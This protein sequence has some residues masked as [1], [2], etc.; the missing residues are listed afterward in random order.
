MGLVHSLVHQGQYAS[1]DLVL[2]QL[3][4]RRGA[5]T[6]QELGVHSL[7]CLD[8]LWALQQRVAIY[9]N[10]YMGSQSLV[11]YLDFEVDL[12]CTLAAFCLPP[13]RRLPCS[14]SLVLPSSSAAADPNELDIDIDVDAAASDATSD[15]G[16]NGGAGE[17]GEDLGGVGVVTRTMSFAAFGVGPLLMHP[18]VWRLF[19]LHLPAVVGS[20][21]CRESFLSA[22]EALGHLL[23][24]SEQ[25]DQAATSSSSFSSSSS[26]SSYSSPSSAEDFTEGYRQSLARRL[27]VQDVDGF[28]FGSVGLVVRGD[29]EQE[30]VLLCHVARRRKERYVNACRAHF[31]GQ[32]SS[33]DGDD[34]NGGGT[35]TGVRRRRK[36]KVVE[37]GGEQCSDAGK[38]EGHAS[39]GEA[40]QQQQQVE[41]WNV[42]DEGTIAQS[43]LPP[44]PTVALSLQLRLGRSDGAGACA[45]AVA[46]GG[47]SIS[48]PQVCVPWFDH[49]DATDKRA[50]GRWGE[51]LVHQ[52]LLVTHKD[53]EVEWLNANQE[54]LAPYDLIIRPPG[55]RTVFVEV[56]ATSSADRMSFPLSLQEWE[57]AINEPRPAYHVYRV[58][59]AGSQHPRVEIFQVLQHITH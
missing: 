27:G 4:A 46:S 42:V 32:G 12:V 30:Q 10:A 47:G 14:T 6:L 57:F 20:P 7:P 51:A 43:V 36:R 25:R 35:E 26:S 44:P 56:K 18:A 54:S 40:Q 8:L 22:A 11:S 17:D 52:L 50:V 59:Q 33:G 21:G 29:L 16:I 41:T 5:G 19:G 23:H 34:G 3:L 58:Y 13:V 55:G 24:Y 37:Q 31:N 39:R 53:A 9:S 49:L 38:P 15:N 45:G 1:F 48:V 28:S 2:A